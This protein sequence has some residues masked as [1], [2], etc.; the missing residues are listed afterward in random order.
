MVLDDGENMDINYVLYANRCMIKKINYN[1]TGRDYHVH[2]LDN[3][4]F[5]IKGGK[6]LDLFTKD[7]LFATYSRLD[8]G[9]QFV[10][11]ED[12]KPILLREYFSEMERKYNVSVKLEN[13]MSRR[14]IIK[15]LNEA[16]ESIKAKQ[17]EKK[18]KKIN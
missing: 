9:D 8:V 6:A 14:Q 18:Q 12:N 5:Y 7:K 1:H 2:E 4:W 16:S 11:I 3:G 10:N 17:L 15:L 13:K